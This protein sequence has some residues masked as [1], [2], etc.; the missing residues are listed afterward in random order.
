MS[1]SFFKKYR[2]QIKVFIANALSEDIGSGD[3]TSLGC[4][5]QDQF[6][7]AELLVKENGRIAGI[8]LAKKIFKQYEPRLS[9]ETFIKDGSEVNNGDV[10]FYVSG[11]SQAILSTERLVLNTLQ[12]MSGI[13]SLTYELNQIIKHTKCRLTD[14]RKT[15]PNFRYAEKWAVQIGGGIN[16]RMGLF[17]AIMIK[18]NHVDFAGGM[19]Q[20]LQKTSDY[21]NKI[22]KNLAV[23][24]E[25]RNQKEVETA[26]RFSFVDRILLDNFLPKELNKIVAS[27]NNIKSTEASGNINKNNIVEYA[28]TGVDFISIGALTYG[29]TCLDLSLKAI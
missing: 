18:D 24:V 10:I 19:K 26:L 14:T 21:M 5:N 3:H 20:T 13:A 7:K 4:I 1:K 22:E 17:D 23:I 2:K 6:S 8:K 16:H 25:C 11:P 15:T 12:R 27:I 28:E 29:A 9:I